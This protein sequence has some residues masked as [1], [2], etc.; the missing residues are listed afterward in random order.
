MIEAKSKVID[1]L[2]IT[3]QAWPAR[4]AWKMQISLG[5]VFGP[6]LKDIGRAIDGNA[7]QDSKKIKSKSKVEIDDVSQ[8]EIDLSALG[9]AFANLFEKL[10]EDTAEEILLKCLSGVRVGKS[11][12]TAETFDLLFMGKIGTIYKVLAFV[13]EVNFGLLFWGKS[14]IGKLL[15]K[16]RI[17]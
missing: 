14:S 17:L 13:M 9:E 7:N 3:V 12:L 15:Q 16:N 2:D 1:D 6:S 10:S 5:K 11:E 8:P 4:K